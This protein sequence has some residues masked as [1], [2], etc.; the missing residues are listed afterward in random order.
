MNNSLRNE[1]TWLAVGSLVVLAVV[2]VAASL[3]YARAVMVPF[4]LAVFVTITVSPVVDF[5]IIR[6]RIPRSLAVI[7]ALLLVLALLVFFGLLVSFAVQPSSA[8]VH[9]SQGDAE[10]A[11]EEY[12]ESM[13]G[14][15]GKM[16]A[17]LQEWNII[18]ETRI[19]NELRDR[20]PYLATQTVGTATGLV[21][22]GFLVVIFTI[23]LLAGR[24]AHRVRSGVYGEIEARIRQYLAAKLA[25]STA[26]GVLVWFVLAMFGL[27]MA[28]LFGLLAFLLNFIPSIGSVIATLL[29]VPVAVAQFSNPWSPWT[30]AGV[31]LIPGTIQMVVGNVI[32][33]KMMGRGLQLHPVTILLSLTFWGLLWGIVGMVLAV[34]IT[35]SIRIV[36]MRF[37]TTQPIGNLLAGELPGRKTPPASMETTA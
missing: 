16:F 20:I 6:W 23:F 27:R 14:L 10:A 26:T 19:S 18:D 31:I 34:P 5:Q 13:A 24:D 21:S 17:K 37:A 28:A 8:E 12:G 32:E 2:A 29:P 22:N 36:L 7:G 1:Q 9:P 25:I 11:G 33:P 4:V 30:I 35:A 3:S 15:F